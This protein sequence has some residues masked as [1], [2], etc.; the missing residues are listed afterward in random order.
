M[1]NNEEPELDQSKIPEMIDRYK[2]YLVES[3]VRFSI[4]NEKLDNL[5]D[6]LQG[7]KQKIK[8]QNTF[9]KAMFILVFGVSFTMLADRIF[10]LF[11]H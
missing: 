4:L 1:R 11:F 7:T 5:R 2:W 9:I 3:G 6:E 10:N 8:E